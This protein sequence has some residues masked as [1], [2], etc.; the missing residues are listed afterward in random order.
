MTRRLAFLLALLLA[1]L[2][3]GMLACDERLSRQLDS[4]D[5]T[6]EEVSK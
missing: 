5:I 4:V 2:A 6:F 1:L 3:V